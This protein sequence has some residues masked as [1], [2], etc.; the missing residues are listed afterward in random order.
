MRLNEAYEPGWIAFE[1]PVKFSAFKLL[2]HLRVNSWAN[3]WQVKGP[4]EILIF[5]WPQALEFS[6]LIFLAVGFFIIAKIKN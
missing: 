4:A 3:G 2:P 6:G 1:L 5:F